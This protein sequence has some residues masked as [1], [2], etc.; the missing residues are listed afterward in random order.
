MATLLFP[1]YVSAM[2]VWMPCVGARGWI[3]GTASPGS[4]N[5]RGSRLASTG[6][7]LNIPGTQL[8]LNDAVGTLEHEHNIYE[9][10]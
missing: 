9:M 1:L 6:K 2:G 10:N 5:N 3:A 8:S 4:S 7:P